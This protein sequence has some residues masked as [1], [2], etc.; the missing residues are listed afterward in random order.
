MI[1]A[2]M[3]LCGAAH[4][5]SL[6]V[7]GLFR[8][9][10]IVTIDGGKPRT[11]A[12]GQQFGD[13]RLVR[14]DSAS[15]VFDVA[16]RQRVLGLGQSFANGPVV[17]ARAS[18]TLT[19][20]PRGHFTA[21]GAVNGQ[22]LNFLVDTGATAVVISADDARRMGLAYKSGRRV[23]VGTANGEILGW[24]VS[25]TQVKLGDVALNQVDGL[26]LETV[27]PQPLLGSSFLNRMEMRREGVVM[28]LTRRY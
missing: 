19:A 8:D 3:L 28:T 15:A 27:L 21:A 13:V 10:A 11:L 24:Q 16:G 4:A 12:V 2:G 5:T 18:I 26:V 6:A 9:K 1:A 14:A 25:F 20:D 23:S 22:P 7:V 17:G